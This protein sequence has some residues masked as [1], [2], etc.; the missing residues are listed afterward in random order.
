MDHLNHTLALHV[1]ALL[2][3]LGLII[4]VVRR[5]KRSTR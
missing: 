4:A 5:W 2:I 3:T 1:L